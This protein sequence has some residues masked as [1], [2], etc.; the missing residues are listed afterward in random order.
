MLPRTLF[1]TVLFASTP[2]LAAPSL[3][4]AD[5]EE[6]R[7]S[8]QARLGAGVDTNVRHDPEA[9]TQ[10]ALARAEL[11]SELQLGRR[12]QVHLSGWFEEHLPFYEL[13]ETDAQLLVL[14]HRP[15]GQRWSLRIGSYGEYQRELATYVEGTVLIHGSTLLSTLAE[16]A[17][18][19]FGVRLGQLDLAFSGQGHLKA[20]S[21][22]PSFNVYGIDGSAALRWVPTH[23]LS[24]RLRYLFL[25]ENVSGLELRDL[26]GA[27]A[28]LRHDLHVRTH[29]LD[30]TMRARPIETLD[31][32][33]RYELAFIDDN[34]LG[35]L[36]G[37]EHRVVAG[38]RFELERRWVVDVAGKMILRNYPLRR[39]AIDNQTRDLPFE[40]IADVGLWLSRHVGLFARYEL[41]GEDARPFGQVYVRHSAVAGVAART[42]VT[43]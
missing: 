31:L 24:L 36:Y 8:L 42:A 28:G 1:L 7:W 34:Y 30:L 35:Y 40:L 27:P 18:L 6:Q 25:F 29:Q 11:D 16:H 33:A 12:L 41:G 21:G 38:L 22:E 3:R 9:S 13:N 23:Y 5:P 39:G 15:L 43:W 19:G 10:A 37:Q 17:S 20:V 32:F 4:P 14:Y 2:A 26:D